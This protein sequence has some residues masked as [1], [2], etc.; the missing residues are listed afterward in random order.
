LFGFW[1]LVVV[2]EKKISKISDKDNSP[3]HRAITINDIRLARVTNVSTASGSTSVAQSNAMLA[4]ANNNN[5]NTLNV[6]NQNQTTGAGGGG[7]SVAATNNTSTIITIKQEALANNVDNL[8]GNYVDSTTFLHSPNSQQ[9]VNP[10]LLQ[11][12]AATTTLGGTGK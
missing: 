5:N 7:G 1:V 9:M 11:N 4:T 10:N 12:T 3:T 8:V 6:N 2:E